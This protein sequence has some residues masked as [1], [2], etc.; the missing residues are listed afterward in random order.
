MK[1]NNLDLLSSALRSVGG[2]FDV[3]TLDLVLSVKELVDQKGT[4]VSIGEIGALA[5]SIADK[6]RTSNQ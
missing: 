5:A 2:N 3:P 1:N 6:Y 4:E